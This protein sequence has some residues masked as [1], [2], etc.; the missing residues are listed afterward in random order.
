LEPN[1]HVNSMKVIENKRRKK[2][3]ETKQLQKDETAFNSGHIIA[4]RML[5]EKII[6][7]KRKK[8]NIGTKTMIEYMKEEKKKKATKLVD[9]LTAYSPIKKSNQKAKSDDEID[10]K[11]KKKNM[12]KLKRKSK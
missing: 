5:F 1:I 4:G 6:L 7:K 8:L 9:A 11:T 10:E 2:L 12:E 3:E